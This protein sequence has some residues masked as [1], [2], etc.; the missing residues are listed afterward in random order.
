MMTAVRDQLIAGTLLLVAGPLLVCLTLWAKAAH[1]SVFATETRRNR[2]GCCYS[3]WRF[4][5]APPANRVSPQ[6]NGDGRYAVYTFCPTSELGQI[7]HRTR[8][9][10]MPGLWNV[11]V[12]DIDFEEFILV[13]AE[14]PGSAA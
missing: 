8:I 3:L 6:S 2:C 4:R 12:G 9:E 14:E 1:G 10:H 11:L 7:L 13:F 5:T